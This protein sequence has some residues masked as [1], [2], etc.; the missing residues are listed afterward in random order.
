MFCDNMMDVQFWVLPDA[1]KRLRH[2]DR[3]MQARSR[4]AKR[5]HNFACLNVLSLDGHMENIHTKINRSRG[6]NL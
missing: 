6:N 1:T 5:P 3:K 2:Q 4:L